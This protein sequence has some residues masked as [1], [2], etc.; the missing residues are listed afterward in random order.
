MFVSRQVAT[1]KSFDDRV[2]KR[3]DET[4]DVK[5]QVSASEKG[6]EGESIR[7]GRISTNASTATSGTAS[8]KSSRTSETGGSTTRRS[9][10]S[11]WRV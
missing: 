2:Y 8:V 1:T 7:G 4:E 11:T 6:S 10:E 9:A 3:V 5:A